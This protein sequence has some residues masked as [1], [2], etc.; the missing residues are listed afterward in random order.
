VSALRTFLDDC[1]ALGWNTEMPANARLF[2]GEGPRFHTGL[3][4]FIS[5]DVMSQLEDPANVA[6]WTDPQA[7]NLFL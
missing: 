4:R 7:R 5:E 1:A 2:P 3:P 6:R